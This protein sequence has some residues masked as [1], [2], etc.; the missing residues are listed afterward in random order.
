VSLSVLSKTFI[1]AVYNKSS[2]DNYATPKGN[3]LVDL[4]MKRERERHCEFHNQKTN[5]K[6]DWKTIAWALL[7]HARMNQKTNTE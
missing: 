4:K 7:T 3:Q 6:Q 5:I 2:F 1:V